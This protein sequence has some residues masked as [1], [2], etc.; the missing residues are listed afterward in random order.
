MTD[1]PSPFVLKPGGK[2]AF[3]SSTQS[4]TRA[5]VKRALP[6]SYV[7]Q[8]KRFKSAPSLP[9]Q[10]PNSSKKG[11]FFRN[12]GPR[13][14]QKTSSRRGGR[15]DS[16]QCV[17]RRKVG[18]C[19][20]RRSSEH[21]A[22]RFTP[23]VPHVSPHFS[24]SSSRGSYKP[25]PGKIPPGIYPRVV[26]EGHCS[27]NN[28]AHASVF[29]ADV[30]CEQEKRQET[31]YSGLIPSEQ[32]D[33]NPSV[34]NGNPRED[35]KAYNSLHVG[36]V[37]GHHRRIPARSYSS[38][39]SMLF[40]VPLGRQDLCFSGHAIRSH[41]S[42]MGLLQSHEAHKGFSSSGSNDL[43]SGRLSYSSLFS[44]FDQDPHQMDVGCSGMAWVF[45]EPREVFSGSPPISGVFGNYVRPSESVFVS[46]TRESGEDPGILSGGSVFFLD[47]QEGVGKAGWFLKLRYKSPISGKALSHPPYPLDESPYVCSRKGSPSSSGLRTEGGS[48]PVVEQGVLGAACPYEYFRSHSRHCQMPQTMAGVESS[49]LCKFRRFGPKRSV[50]NQ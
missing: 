4:T 3:K 33:Y 13:K 47:D 42:P 16:S 49:Y 29:L 40:R 28:R 12:Q 10:T 35:S 39:L 50:P 30:H 38:R 20:R 1:K 48:F 2:S 22:R 43:L 5:P 17:T 25:R 32:V 19:W 14:F 27:G 26:G 41:Y 15:T 45:S 18:L 24:G 36:D 44:I 7:N 34:Q 8:P 9:V 37:G 31:A 6:Y 11:R 21:Y 46:P 23:K